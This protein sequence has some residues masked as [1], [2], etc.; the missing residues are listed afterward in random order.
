VAE[1]RQKACL[2]SDLFV[3]LQPISEINALIT[4]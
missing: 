3:I 2:L 4:G 1:K